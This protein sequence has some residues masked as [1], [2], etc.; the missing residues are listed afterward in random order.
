MNIMNKK[1]TLLKI[2]KWLKLTVVTNW[3]VVNLHHFEVIMYFF[4][5]TWRSLS[6]NWTS[7]KLKTFSSKDSIK[8]VKNEVTDSKR[9]N[10]HLGRPRQF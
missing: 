10:V 6:A 7:L 4:K 1:M 3:M 8:G 9:H 2:S 5:N